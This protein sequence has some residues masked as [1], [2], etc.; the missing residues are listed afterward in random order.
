MTSDLGKSVNASRNYS[1]VGLLLAS[2]AALGLSAAPVGAQNLAPPSGAIMDLNGQPLPVIDPTYTSEE[3][4]VN[5]A[6]I[7]DG[8]TILTFLFR[9]D[10]AYIDFSSVALY[11]LSSPT[12]TVNLL[13]NGNFAG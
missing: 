8:A 6:D 13:A 3:F 11:D 9:D 12:P 2:V 1:L 10:Y 5:P 7:V 4:Q